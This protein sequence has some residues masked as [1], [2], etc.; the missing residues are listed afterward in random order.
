MDCQHLEELH[1]LNLLGALSE[2]SSSDVVAHLARSCP[3]CLA[4]VHEAMEI[5]YVL[6]LRSKPARP[7]PRVKAKLLEKILPKREPRG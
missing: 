5:I 2:Q 4:R 3:H 7:H 6:C 1:E